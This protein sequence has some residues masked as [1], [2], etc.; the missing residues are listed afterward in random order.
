MVLAGESCIEGITD[1]FDEL[2]IINLN[3]QYQI[4]K[5]LIANKGTETDRYSYLDLGSI[6]EFM[7]KRIENYPVEKYRDRMFFSSILFQSVID[8][9]SLKRGY[10]N[11]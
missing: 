1:R 2:K 7:D 10:D 3:D 11:K 5:V 6:I 9:V 4:G 8:R